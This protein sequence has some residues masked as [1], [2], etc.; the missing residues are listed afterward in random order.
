MMFRV[1]FE[2]PH[3]VRSRYRIA[4]AAC[5]FLQ[6]L[7]FASWASRIPDIK[8][9]LQLSEAALG[10]VLFAIP[11]GQLCALTLSGFLV[12]RFGS[13]RMLILAAICYPACLVF[14]GTATSVWHLATGLFFFGMSANLCNIS[15]NTQGVGVERLYRRSI[16]ATFHGLWSLAGF[17]GGLLSTWM[18]GQ[19]IMPF[20]HFCV[21]FVVAMIILA[22]S[23][24]TL[25]PR[26]FHPVHHDEAGREPVFVK[27]DRY[28]VLLGLI[29]FGSMVCEG[30]MFD[31]SA[32]YFEQ[33]IDPP[34]SLIRL[35]YIAGMCT[36]ACGRFLADRLVVRFGIIRVLRTSG[37]LI[38]S[39][40]LLSVLFPY[41]ETA[42]FGFLLIGLGVSSVVPLSYSMAG[43]SRKMQ[44]GVALTAVSSIG[45]L[46]FLIGPPLIG[47]VAHAL[48]LRWAFAIIACLGLMTTVVAGRLEKLPDY[49]GQTKESL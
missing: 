13:R 15:V 23:Y 1:N 9:A 17:I 2:M 33:V 30:T 38:A 14:L 18:V 16:M 4:V 37:I 21:V 32:V 29:A 19:N 34:K 42:T 6:G 45:F 20:P 44:P 46:G 26:D 41:I 8:S 10:S 11:I 12:T 3:T 48:S 7:V 5:Y 25:L 27:P 24:R 36:M 35:G 39:G 49:I 47:Y 28:I 22:C 43:R 40:F 31:W